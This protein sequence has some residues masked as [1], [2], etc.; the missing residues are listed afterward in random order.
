MVRPGDVVVRER[1][2]EIVEVKVEP[3]EDD[4]DVGI[5]EAG[6]AGGEPRVVRRV[7]V[8]PVGGIA[9]TDEGDLLAGELGFD[10]RF[11]EDED[12]VLGR[13][14]RHDPRDVDCG[15]IG[16]AEDFFDGSGDAHVGELFLVVRARF[17]RVVGY[18]DD[19]FVQGAQEVEGFDGAGEEVVA[20]PEDAWGGKRKKG[21]GV[22]WFVKFR[23]GRLW[24]F[25]YHRSRRGRPERDQRA[26]CMPVDLR[27]Y[28]KSC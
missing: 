17:G 11:A 27:T 12:F 6:V 4:G 25:V 8:A 15:R 21:D 2:L 3:G 13:G 10:A 1:E 9:A 19:L 16:G 22:S 14:Q 18:E 23:D 20:G 26:V 5:E 7:D 24:A 28:V